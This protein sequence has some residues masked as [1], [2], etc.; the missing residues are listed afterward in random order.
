MMGPSYKSDVEKPRK[1]KKVAAIEV[2]ENGDA[3]TVVSGKY[4]AIFVG[5]EYVGYGDTI[6]KA[7]DDMWNRMLSGVVRTA[8]ELA[9]KG[10]G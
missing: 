4:R 6:T 7:I 1:P 10:R 5:T 3:M 8:L 9:A 2:W